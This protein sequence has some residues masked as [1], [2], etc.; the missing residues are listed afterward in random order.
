MSKG[1]GWA[2]ALL[3]VA[4]CCLG[5]GGF[6]LKTILD[7]KNERGPAESAGRAYLDAVESDDLT[8][9]YAM[10]CRKLHGTLTLEEFEAAQA[11]RHRI[12]RYEVTGF[13][14]VNTNGHVS[15]SLETRM[16]L[17]AGGTVSQ[18]LPLV[19]E[20]GEWHPCE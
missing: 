11:N 20:D 17:T 15:G 8:G 13:N 5:V 16:Y 7:S 18:R 19:K 6:L 12:A 10:T 14:Y 4:C 3:T 2:L 1:I 9:A